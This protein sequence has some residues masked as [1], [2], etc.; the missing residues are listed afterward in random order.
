[1]SRRGWLLFAAMCV[2]WGMPYLM[3]KV[4]VVDISPAALVFLR[5]GLGA[6]LLLPIALLR[7]QIRP[8]FARWKPLLAYT[9]VEIAVPWLLIGLAEQQL[10]SGLTG[11]LV[12]TVPLVG[13][14]IART[15]GAHERLG[16]VR[17]TGLLVGFAG[18][19]ALVGID[20][21]GANLWAVLAMLG[22]A[23]GYALGPIML[24]RYLSDAPGL[25]VVAGSLTLC[26]V[27]YAP[28]G[29]AQLPST[30]P[31]WDVV[32]AVVGLAVI[33]TAL[34]FLVFFRLIAEVG[35]VRATVFTYVNPAVA[36][37]LG[38]T[39]LNEPVTLV[40]AAGFVLVLT[41][42][43]LA[44]RRPKPVTGGSSPHSASGSA[45]SRPST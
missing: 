8:L 25:G 35:P 34:A 24:S 20:L 13:A 14:I 43:I 38:A 6:V 30:M 1:M 41:G 2:I 36:I 44:T 45:A 19:A 42:S 3:I 15:T 39:L 31:G 4:A 5:T 37:A 33:C 7:G 18:V 23:V 29:I 17:V 32:A 28:V 11:L 16:G 40:T 22:V 9:L 12:A 10:S 21:G 27:G 26:A